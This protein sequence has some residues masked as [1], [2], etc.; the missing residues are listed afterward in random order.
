MTERAMA[1]R[2]LVTCA[3]FCYNQV[4]FV[5]DAV[6]GMLSQDYSPLEVILS[7]DASTD[8][9]S[10]VLRKC[11]ESYSGPHRVVVKV[12]ERNLGL[13]PHINKVMGMAQGRL[14]VVGAG[15]DVSLP[16]RV[17]SI[18]AAWTGAGRGAQALYSRFIAM[19][20]A[21]VDRGVRQLRTHDRFGDRRHVAAHGGFV[22]GATGAWSKD[23]FE[24]FGPLMPGLIQE[25]HAVPFRAS[26]LDGVVFIEEPLVRYREDV[27]HWWRGVS[28]GSRGLSARRK[29]F[30]Q[31]CRLE[32]NNAEQAMADLKVLGD[33]SLCE[34]GRGRLVR[35]RAMMRLSESPAWSPRGP[36]DAWRAGVGLRTIVLSQVR[37][38]VP[39]GVRLLE[40]VEALR[41]LASRGG[42]SG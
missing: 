31:H 8:G 23:L 19:D 35:A 30:Q 22:L 36:W 2:E 6:R 16:H 33:E 24:R 41:T 38:N 3:M 40:S 4:E 18:H 39:G 42:R 28:P 37:T 11:A 32:C 21:G 20:R 15:D 5:A 14:I 27:S 10:D 29:R 26:M 17:S 13:T 9:T 7:D 34:L 12:N 25:D 1:G